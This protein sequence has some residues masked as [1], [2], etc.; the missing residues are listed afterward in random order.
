[1]SPRARPS[2]C[3]VQ[4]CKQAADGTDETKCLTPIEICCLTCLDASENPIKVLPCTFKHLNTFENAFFD[5]LGIE[6]QSVSKDFC[7]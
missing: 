2:S 1:M 6:G 4:R 3:F 5:H 7:S